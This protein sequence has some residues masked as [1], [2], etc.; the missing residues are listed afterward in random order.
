MDTTQLVYSPMTPLLLRHPAW[1][2]VGAIGSAGGALTAHMGGSDI[3]SGVLLGAAVA[4]ALAVM[5]TVRQQLAAS[6]AR[7][8]RLP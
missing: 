4:F 3:L 6:R 5:P 1:L 7:K 8:A 2:M